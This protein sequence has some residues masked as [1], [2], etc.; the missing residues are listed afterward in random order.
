MLSYDALSLRPAAFRSLTGMAPADFDAL[1]ADFVAA[2]AERRR[3]AT[4]TKR[5]TPRRRACGAGH[6]L[7]L[8]DRHR[9]LLALAWLRLYPTYEVLGLLFGLDRGNAHRNAEDVLATL[10]ALE[11]FP[12]ERPPADRKRLGSVAAVMDAFPQVRLVIDAKQQRVE[13]PR[14]EAR[15]RPF[16]SGKKRCHTLKTQVAVL[17]D[18]RLGAVSE[19]VPGGAGH[20]LTP[21]RRSGLLDR[22]DPEADEGAM[23]DKGYVGAGDGYPDLPLFLPHR[24][25]RGRPLTEEQKADNRLVARYRIVVEHTLAQMARYQALRQLWRSDVGRHGRAVRAVAVLVDRRIRQV[26]LKTYAVA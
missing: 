24:A 7:A 12:F 26:P 17:P 13:R 14:G 25:W 1:L 2:Q 5:G 11:T 21:L 15:Q 19:S 10:A 9:L 22:L 6:P 3:V 23:L 16:Y 18:G 4:T 8:D 20:D